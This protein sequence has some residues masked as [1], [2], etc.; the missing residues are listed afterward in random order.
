MKKNKA[1][2]I[3]GVLA[4]VFL[5]FLLLYN[6]NYK[7]LLTSIQFMSNSSS[8]SLNCDKTNVVVGDSVTC[9]IKANIVSGKMT[10]FQGK[11]LLSNNLQLISSTYSSNWSEFSSSSNGFYQLSTASM[12]SGSVDIG[13]FVV[14]VL[15]NNGDSKISIDNIKIGNENYNEVAL[16]G[17]SHSLKVLSKEDRLAGLEVNNGELSSIFNR[18]V[19]NYTVTTNSDTI[20]IHATPPAL[21]SV[22]GD[23]QK[24]LNYGK[25]VFKIVSLAEAGNSREY[26]ITVIRNDTRDSNNHLEKLS[27][28]NTNIKF[29][30]N[31]VSY[32][33]TVSNKI[34]T[35]TISAS[36]A[37]SK[38][39]VTGVGKKKLNVGKNIFTVVVTA[40]NG[41]S[42]S[43][44]ITI[45]RKNKS[46]VVPD[47]VT[48][49]E[50]KKENNDDINS[51]D[52]IV[53]SD[54]NNN[55]LKYLTVLEKE[56]DFSKGQLEYS[57]HVNYDVDKLN[58]SYEAENPN[59][60]VEI[61]DTNLLVGDNKIIIKVV[62]ESGIEREY[63]LN[64]VRDKMS[65]FSAQLP[66]DDKKGN[67]H[68]TYYLLIRTLIVGILLLIA[69]LLHKKFSKK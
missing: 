30:A 23:G 39:K 6:G 22:T 44:T 43:Y 24:K 9:N 35:V 48:V 27:V 4:I 69:Y 59:S 2:L 21:G 1:I 29:N 55:Y 40:E 10:S 53:V 66:T 45:N 47:K 57:F 17:N 3:Y 25:N 54:K 34:D 15:S 33:D 41:D 16:S 67:F 52:T 49:N 20:S 26:T 38:A 68:L 12:F 19:F 65:I 13:H 50:S 58:I 31:Q 8:I 46:G 61:S 60:K 5:S 32:S 63:V 51:S 14:K 7:N 28:S 37:S 56:I 62:A 36:V 18:D 11:I 64:V 42:K